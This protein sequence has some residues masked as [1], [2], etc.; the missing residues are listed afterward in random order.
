[1][2]VQVQIDAGDISSDEGGQP[3][4]QRFKKPDEAE[5]AAINEINLD[6]RR[7]TILVNPLNSKDGKEK[8][9]FDEFGM[10]LEGELRESMQIRS[11]DPVFEGKVAA[12]RKKIENEIASK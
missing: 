7:S 12:H 10:G 3:L 2:S 8:E 1:M 4:D 6:R 9:A 11:L 5:K